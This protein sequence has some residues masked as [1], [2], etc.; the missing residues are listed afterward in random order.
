VRCHLGAAC[1]LL[2]LVSLV[3]AGCGGSGTIS[4]SGGGS[5]SSSAA[6]DPGAEPAAGGV[7][8]RQLG[9]QA[10]RGLT[11]LQAAHRYRVAARRAGV[12]RHFAALV[13]DPPP[14]IESSPGYPRLVASFYATTVPGPD[15]REAAAGCAEELAAPTGR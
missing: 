6:A 11:P 12:R 2:A 10:C 7:A 8:A 9:R 15:R 1:V 4:T 13:V 5:G 3:A 14:A